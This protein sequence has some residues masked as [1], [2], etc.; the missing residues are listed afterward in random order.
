MGRKVFTS[1]SLQFFIAT[2]KCYRLSTTISTIPNSQALIEEGKMVVRTTLRSMVNAADTSFSSIGMAFVM[3]HESWLY[4]SGFSR[5]VQNTMEDLTFDEAHLFNEN[6][7]APKRKKLSLTN[8]DWYLSSFIQRSY[9]PPWKTQSTE[10]S[11]PCPSHF[12]NI[13]ISPHGKRYF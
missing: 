9:D 2:V 4:A 3:H 1:T 8:L 5:E 13:S 11:F 10:V 12:Y 7:L 6:A